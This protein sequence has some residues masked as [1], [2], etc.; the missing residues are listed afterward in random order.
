MQSSQEET[1]RRPPLEGPST[2]HRQVLHHYAG[3]YT[4]HNRG[5]QAAYNPDLVPPPSVRPKSTHTWPPHTPLS[6]QTPFPTTIH[7]T[8]NAAASSPAVQAPPS[9]MLTPPATIPSPSV[10]IPILDVPDTSQSP[11]ANAQGPPLGM[12]HP[13]TLTRGTTA[14]THSA[15]PQTHLYPV[16][17]A[18]M[19]A[20]YAHQATGHRPSVPVASPMYPQTA[21]LRQASAHVPRT[22]M[23]SM[24][25]IPPAMYNPQAAKYDSSFHQH[26]APFPAIPM[27]VNPYQNFS[28]PGVPIIGQASYGPVQLTP[29]GFTQTHQVKNVQVF[30]G[31]P[32]CKIL[33]ED[34][35]RDMQYLLE[36]GGLPIHLCFATIVRHLS[37]EAR[38]LILHLPLQ[39]QHPERAFDELR[40][41]Y[42]D[43]QRSLDPLAD[44]YERSQRPDET[45]C[46]Y[47]IALEATLR[48]VEEAQP[49]GRPFPDRDAKLTRQFLRGLS[50]EEVYLRISPMKPRLLSF[51]EV[52]EELRNLARETKKFHQHKPKKPFTQVHV[53]TGGQQGGV[54]AEAVKPTSELSEL[55]ALVQKLALSQEEQVKKLAELESKMNPLRT[56][57]PA[58]NQQA[59]RAESEARPFV[60]FRC[61]MAGH[62]ARVCRTVMPGS[63]TT[64]N[65]PTPSQE[66]SATQSGQS[67]NA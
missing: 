50:D 20:V 18:H 55:T 16:S 65:T 49:G 23:N 36:A 47:A 8:A 32:D 56:P 54:K 42:G 19:S 1:P 7:P 15:P 37:G 61:G 59:G 5:G 60:C 44:F 10:V 35:I 2:V 26:P 29:A 48:S 25:A 58:R 46:S 6:Y 13:S 57:A 22:L 62:V 17:Q 27:A 64:Q 31:N 53:A 12:Q 63:N 3:P 52:Q 39:E 14:I 11:A 24:Q 9:N 38:R 40:A 33:I 28:S 67:L 4:D 45:A 43:I 51:R 66:G 34:W 30:S 21:D 41:E